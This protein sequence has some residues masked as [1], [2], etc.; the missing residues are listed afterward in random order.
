M[1]VVRKRGR[2]GA[3]P[4]LLPW[5]RRKGVLAR[6]GTTRLSGLAAFGI[7]VVALFWLRAREQRKT[8]VR[9]TRATLLVVRAGLDAYRAEHAGECPK[10]GLEELAAAGRLSRPPRDAWGRPLRLVC[11]SRRPDRPYDLSSDGPD[12]EEGGLDRVE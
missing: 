8:D 7:L 1:D 2:R 4:I 12:G 11:P 3:Q 10:G 9:V 6:L 5:E